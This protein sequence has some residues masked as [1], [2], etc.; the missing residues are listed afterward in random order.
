MKRLNLT[1]DDAVY[2][3]LEDRAKKEHTSVSM[4][5]YN[6]IANSHSNNKIDFVKILNNIYK[7]ID[8]MKPCKFTLNDLDSFKKISMVEYNGGNIKLATIRARIGK[9]FY[10]SV[11]KKE[12]NKV[13]VAK[14]SDGNVQK[15]FNAILYI[16]K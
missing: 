11:E 13:S 14:D 8:K 2:S 7:E 3:A 10:K 5:V 9:N 4:Y 1:I 16:K 6:F 12:V 15:R